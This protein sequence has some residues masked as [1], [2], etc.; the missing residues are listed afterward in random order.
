MSSTNPYNVSVTTFAKL[1]GFSTRNIRKW[2]DKGEI[3][4]WQPGGNYGQWYIN[5]LE[6]ERFI[7][8]RRSD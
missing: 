3:D 4:A 1:T 5:R 7:A 6:L 2:C 8:K